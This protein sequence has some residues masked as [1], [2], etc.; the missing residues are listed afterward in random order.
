MPPKPPY[1]PSS[2]DPTP[3]S[4]ELRRR[5]SSIR[6]EIRRDLALRE[7]QMLMTAQR[8][9]EEFRQRAE[10]RMRAQIQQEEEE[11]FF[12]ERGYERYTNRYGQT[13]WITPE[14]VQMRRQF[15]RREFWHSLARGRSFRRFPKSWIIGIL[16]ALVVLV[17]A[18]LALSIVKRPARYGRLVVKSE[19]AGARIWVDGVDRGVNTPAVLA[20]VLEGRRV[21]TVAKAG[22]SA[23]PPVQ[24]IDI[25][26]D[27]DNEL[28]FTLAGIA[29]LGTVTVDANT[30]TPFD[31]YVDGIRTPF[32]EKNK[33]SIP[34]GYHVL[35]P[36]RDGFFADP[37]F[38][39]ILVSPDAPVKVKFTF[40]PDQHMGY[41][42]LPENS[43]GPY[44]Y[45][46]GRFTGL[47]PGF[48]EVRLPLKKGA[49]ELLFP[50]REIRATPE[51]QSVVIEPGASRI[52]QV[53]FAPALLTTAELKVRT[54]QPG[55]AVVLDGEWLPWVTPHVTVRLVPGRH[56]LN[57]YR[58]GAWL[59]A[60]DLPVTV[61]AGKAVAL[62]YEF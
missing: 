36:I 15:K 33:L 57:L 40:Y 30:E 9:E 14:E 28:T 58:N 2:P 12:A 24:A 43:R 7:Q 13:E 20:S 17:F 21:I 19:P 39:R 26:A 23:T 11:R 34:A 62:N 41:L 27:R 29:K 54:P 49:C 35:T 10:A 55:A 3:G 51:Q 42:Q 37:P 31:L 45:A 6:E 46:N 48:G 52:F 56:F 38:Q 18:S 8:E 16:I 60:E 32:D 53:S 1:Q 44:L 59:S 25:R 5:E 4:D 50:A 61:E 22:Y 47:R